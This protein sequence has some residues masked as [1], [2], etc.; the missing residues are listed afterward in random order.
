MLQEQNP[1]CARPLDQTNYH[2]HGFELRGLDML[3]P[4]RDQAIDLALKKAL[5]QLGAGWEL[6]HIL[7]GLP[8]EISHEEVSWPKLILKKKRERTLSFN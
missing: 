6:D 7:P 8:F 4:G 5:K 1:Y 3:A 2:Y